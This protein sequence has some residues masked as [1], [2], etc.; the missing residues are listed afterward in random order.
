ML[1]NETDKPTKTQNKSMM[2]PIELRCI[3]LKDISDNVAN[4]INL[5]PDACSIMVNNRLLK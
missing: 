3:R 4:F 1:G 5:F 2:P